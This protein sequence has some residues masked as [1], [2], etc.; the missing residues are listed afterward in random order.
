M[1][2][3]QHHLCSVSLLQTSRN[4]ETDCTSSDDR[5]REVCFS[6]NA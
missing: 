2:L 4:S 1:F 3:N 6:G 5:V